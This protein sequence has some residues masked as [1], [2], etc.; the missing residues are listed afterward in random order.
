MKTETMFSHKSDD[1]STP[2]D[3]FQDLD[4]EFHFTLDPCADEYNHKCDKWFDISQ[5][6]LLQSW[7]G[8]RVFCNP[9]YGRQVGAWCKKAYEEVRENGCKLVVMLIG[10]RTDTKWFHDW[11]YGKAEMRFVKGRLHFGG[12]DRAPFPSIVCIYRPEFA[13]NGLRLCPFCGNEPTIR[14]LKGKDGWRD[15]YA[16]ICNYD[17]GGC[18]AESGLY[19]YEAEAIDAWNR[20]IQK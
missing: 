2:Q 6:G 18:G 12:S 16:V 11:V 19:H 8:E 3:F 7:R 5:D 17:D 10:G 4:E 20:R 15:R 1:W 9:P 13:K 14:I